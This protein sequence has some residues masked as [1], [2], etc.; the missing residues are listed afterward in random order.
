MPNVTVISGTPTGA[1]FV[2]DGI[3]FYQW[4]F[5]VDINGQ[6]YEVTEWFDTNNPAAEPGLA[7]DV[8]EDIENGSVDPGGISE[9]DSPDNGRDDDDGDDDGALAS[10]G[11]SDYGDSV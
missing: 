3:T 9:N 5:T 1:S 11:G 4:G 7:Q 10:S 6:V 2:Y 8:I